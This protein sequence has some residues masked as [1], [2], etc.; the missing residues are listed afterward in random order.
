MAFAPTKFA[1]N[2]PA[3]AVAQ[4]SI[5]TG[6]YT[7]GRYGGV[8]HLCVDPSSNALQGSYSEA[9]ILQGEANNTHAWGNFYEAGTEDPDHERECRHRCGAS[10]ADVGSQLPHRL[11]H[12]AADRTWL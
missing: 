8:T 9:G 2:L 3:C 6:T 11:L 7:H 4:S 10:R 12:G 1:G 5:W